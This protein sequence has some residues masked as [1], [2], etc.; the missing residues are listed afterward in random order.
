M[1]HG[2]EFSQTWSTGEGN[3][4]LLQYCCLGKRSKQYEK[5]KN[6]TL[7]DELPSSVDAQNA[8]G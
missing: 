3:G 6:M 1:G 2:G 8:T 5:A 7:K 4:K